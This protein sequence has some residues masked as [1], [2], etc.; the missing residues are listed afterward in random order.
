MLQ[1]DELLTPK[2]REALQKPRAEAY[3]DKADAF[4]C[5]QLPQRLGALT[6]PERKSVIQQAY[7]QG[8]D[9][10]LVSDGDQLA[11]LVAV[12]HLGM[13][14]ETDPQFETL[15]SAARWADPDNRPDLS[16]LAAE[17]DRYR[18]TVDDDLADLQRLVTVFERHF[19]RSGSEDGPEACHAFMTRS[20]PK[21]TARLSE[22]T[23]PAFI[24]SAK[25]GVAALGVTGADL[26]CHVA[27]ALYFGHHFIDDPQHAWV[28]AAYQNE[29]VEDRRLALGAGVQA[30]LARFGPD[31]IGRPAKER[32]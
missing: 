24:A 5:K 11:Y 10:G 9:R 20:F 2:V 1:L 30:H 7:L 26:V 32:L 22:R 6:P 8:T 27:L 4:A 17:M 15:L 14:F 18:T 3:V 16:R 25:A 29:K 21:R 13:F 28:H 19:L 12:A 31:E 23:G